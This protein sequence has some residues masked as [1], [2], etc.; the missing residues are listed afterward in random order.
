MVYAESFCDLE[1]DIWPSFQGHC[2]KRLKSRSLL[3]LGIR[4]QSW[5]YREWV[6][7]N[8]L[9]T[10]NLTF[11]LIFKVIGQNMLISCLVLTLEL[12]KQLWTIYD[13][14]YDKYTRDHEFDLWP[15]FQGHW[16]KWPISHSL[17]TLHFRN[18]LWTSSLASVCRIRLHYDH[19]EIDAWRICGSL[20]ADNRTSGNLFVSPWAKT[21]KM[22]TY[23]CTLSGPISRYG[24]STYLAWDCWIGVYGRPYAYPLADFALWYD[25]RPQQSVQTGER[26]NLVLIAP[27]CAY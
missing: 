10:L 3:T 16:T 25:H 21:P 17:L 18:Q 6:L 8:I 23:M 26:S 19:M 7:L 11:D 13:N 24:E 22:E 12:M 4:N 20:V 15:H 2:I 1:F 9:L 14:I 27:C 5:T